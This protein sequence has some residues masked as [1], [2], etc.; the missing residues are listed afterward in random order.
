VNIYKYWKNR[1]FMYTEGHAVIGISTLRVVR[2]ERYG[3]T[4]TAIIS[5][6]F[7]DRAA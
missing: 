7:Y 2:K 6:K 3:N 4:G 1:E 5:W